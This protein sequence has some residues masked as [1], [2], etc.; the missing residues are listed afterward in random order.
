MQ[1]SVYRMGMLARARILA[2]LAA[3]L[4]AGCPANRALEG[5][6][7]PDPDGPEADDVLDARDPADDP[8]EELN[9][10]APPSTADTWVVTLGGEGGQEGEAVAVAEAP[11]GGYVVLGSTR[12]PG[13]YV[14]TDAWLFAL[15]P[16]GNVEWQETI[17]DAGIDIGEAM[18]M[19]ADG[20][21][22]FAGGTDLSDAGDDL[23]P[24]LGRTDAGGTLLWEKHV[25]DSGFN[26]LTAVAPD[27]AGGIVVCGQVYSYEHGGD[28][29]WIARIDGEGRIQWQRI[30]VGSGL[31]AWPT[32]AVVDAG[33]GIVVAGYVY[34][35]SVEGNDAWIAV[36]DMDGGLTWQKR[37]DGFPGDAIVAVSVDGEGTLYAAGAAT[38]S[39]LSLVWMF[40]VKVD[41]RGR[42]LETM[43]YIVEQEFAVASAVFTREG[44]FV[45]AGGRAYPPTATHSNHLLAVLAEDLLVQHAVQFGVLESNRIFSVIDDATGSTVVAGR[46]GEYVDESGFVNSRL[47]VARLSSLLTVEA[48]PRLESADVDETHGLYLAEVVPGI[49]FLPADNALVDGTAEVV[50]THVIPRFICPE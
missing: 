37:L 34:G 9:A 21:V 12:E 14:N 28:V 39:S 18:A 41:D 20:S 6:A 30:A 11:D 7:E 32:S 13:G 24:W 8:L 4:L 48:C 38:D 33:V 17:G 5:D 15:D 10:D 22:V 27:H 2:A 35:S 19:L 46:T 1:G 45:V 16:H 47:V 31:V 49:T 42:V 40:V 36:L 29:A 43:P 26:K 23:T 50:E 25:T 3:I 44:R